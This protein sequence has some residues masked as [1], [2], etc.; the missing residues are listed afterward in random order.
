[1][2]AMTIVGEQTGEDTYVVTATPDHGR[3]VKFNVGQRTYDSNGRQRL[4]YLVMTPSGGMLSAHR[5][6][7]KAVFEATKRAKRYVRA[8]SKPRMRT[9]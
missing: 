9:R 6:F 2:S 8:Y 1:M 3:R 7:E 5:S 4:G